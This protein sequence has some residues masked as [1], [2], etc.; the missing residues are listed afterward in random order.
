MQIIE[1]MQEERGLFADAVD[2]GQTLGIRFQNAGQ[3]SE[4]VQ[5]PVRKLVDVLSGDHIGEQVFQNDMIRHAVHALFPILFPDAFP[6]AASA[7]SE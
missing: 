1:R 6:A 3:R 7:A 2:C 5:K 4:C